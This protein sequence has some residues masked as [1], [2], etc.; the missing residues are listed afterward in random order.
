MTEILRVALIILLLT[1]GFACYFLVLGAFFPRRLTKTMTVVQQMPGRSFG[2][3]LVNFLFFGTITILLFAVAENLQKSGNNFPYTILMIPT[4]FLTGLLLGVLFIGLLAMIT[5]LGEQLF[6]DLSQW[7][8][9]FWGTVIFAFACAVPAL[10]WFLL[11]PA[12]ALTGFG[13]FIL[14]LFQRNP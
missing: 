7:R 2:I 1:L 5:L 8:R 10:G 12:V 6:P 14:G 3:G 9:T 13:A 11:F 4:L